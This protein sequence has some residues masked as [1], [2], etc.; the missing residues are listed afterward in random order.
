MARKPPSTKTVTSRSLTISTN[1]FCLDF[2]WRKVEMQEH[3]TTPARSY[4][5]PRQQ[6][7][8][9]VLNRKQITELLAPSSQEPRILADP[10]PISLGPLAGPSPAQAIRSYRKTAM[11][12]DD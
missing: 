4:T 12:E 9:D 6:S 3:E 2:T 5:P 10:L 8:A 11:L 7:F 1:N